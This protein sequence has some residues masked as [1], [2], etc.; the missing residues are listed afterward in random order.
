MTTCLDEA[1]AQMLRRGLDCVLT[2]PRFNAQI[3]V[4]AVQVAEHIW[5]QAAMGVRDFDQMKYSALSLLTS[6]AER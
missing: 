6:V 3:S 2:D 4:S 1:S 5:R